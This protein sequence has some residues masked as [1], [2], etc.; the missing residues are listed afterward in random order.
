M[1]KV[2]WRQH[3]FIL[4]TIVAGIATIH[5]VLRL[6]VSPVPFSENFRFYQ[7]IL[8]LQAITLLIQYGCYIWLN[9]FVIAKLSR[10]LQR[11][12]ILLERGN[13]QPKNF[14]ISLLKYAWL[15]LQ[16]LVIIYLLGPVSNFAAYYCTEG[17]PD[18]GMVNIISSILPPHPQPTFNTFGGFDITLF[19]VCVYL[20][21]ALFRE[22]TIYF[23]EHNGGRA[24]F[25]VL[26][27]NQVTLLTVIY[28]SVLP[29]LII[30]STPV[31]PVF[32]GQS[33]VVMYFFV[34][35]AA[36]TVALINIYWLF[37]LKGEAPF[38]KS[39]IVGRLLLVTAIGAVPV[40]FFQRAGLVGPGGPGAFFI[41]GWLFQLFVVTPVSWVV[42]Q[43]RKDKILQVRG[44]EQA[45][46]KSKADMQ[47]LRS[48]I[49]PHFLFNTLNTLYGTALQEGSTR[50]AEGIQ[51]LGDMMRF[52]LH[53]NN[54][55]FILLSREVEYMQ[56]YITLQKLR[57]QQSPNINI[58][59]N[60]NGDGC[61]HSIAPMLLIPLVENAFKHGISLV[62]PSWIKIQLACDAK[63]IRFTVNNS[64]HTKQESD[65]EKDKSGVGLQNVSSRLALLYPNRYAFSAEGD[66]KEFTSLLYIQF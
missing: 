56:N 3:E 14:G 60:I 13:V 32:M 51:M 22:V 19:F 8:L 59:T 37:P 39:K 63:S 11:P 65:T 31:M 26:V 53:E 40:M 58:E 55:D 44:M 5:S 46:N 10:P 18:K 64:M 42:Y 47:F 41:G 23:I 6:L 16:F 54:R 43:Q 38:L 28:L 35:P 52:M 20:V 2:K 15:G 30:F 33:T 45:L 7:N 12:V 29:V 21:Y 66:G 62:E 49:N 34:I 50:T 48:Q 9:K 4:V 17:F 57:I 25:R 27:S 36:I 1:A 61:N 24:A